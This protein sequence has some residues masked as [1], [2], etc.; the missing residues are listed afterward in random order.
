MRGNLWGLVVIALALALALPAVNIGFANAAQPGESVENTTVDYDQN[1]T[2]GNN[3]VYEYTSLNV[4]ANTTQL[5]EG[6]DYRFDTANG[7]ISWLDTL[8]T[9]DGDDATVQYEFTDHDETTSNQKR[10]LQTVATPVGFLALMITFGYL[11]VLVF[12]DPY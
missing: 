1:Y 8:A 9:A 2:L 3:D 12:R 11:L 7:T 6:T 5:S 10:L 4:T